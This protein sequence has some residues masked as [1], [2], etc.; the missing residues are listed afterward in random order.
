MRFN[1]VIALLLFPLL[2]VSLTAKAAIKVNYYQPSNENDRYPIDL[3]SFLLDKSGMDYQLN[4]VPSENLTEQRLI[5]DVQ[6]GQVSFISMA[7]NERLNNELHAI[8]YPMYRGL[9]GH[10]VFIIR[11]GDQHKFDGINSVAELNRLVG[12]QGRFWADT[13]VLKSAGLNVET[14]VKYHSL[15][16]MLE[17]ERFDY[18]P[19]AIHEPLNEIAARPELDLTIEKNLLLV[20]P[21]PMLLYTS[22]ANPELYK[23]LELGFENA[24]QDGSFAKWFVEHPAIEQVLSKI[25]LHNRTVLRLDNPHLPAGTPVHR[26][27]LWLDIEQLKKTS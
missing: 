4:G 7:T 5:S 1:R 19:R 21:M 3:V 16:Y 26:K 6:S 12:G 18:F 17:G 20:Y 25:E 24:I 27:E 8:Q 10:R 14:P 13:A 9:L 11:Q 2:V 22:K 15:F 23:A